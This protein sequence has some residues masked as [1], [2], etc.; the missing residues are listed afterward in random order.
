MENSKNSLVRLIV[1]G[2]DKCKSNF[3]KKT[4]RFLAENG[5][6]AVTNQDVIFPLSYLYV[7]K[8]P[9]NPYYKNDEIL[10][11][12]F[13]GGDA[14]RNA[15]DA[16]GKVEFVKIDGSK[17]GKTYMCWS[18]FHW[19]ET[20]RLLKNFLPSERANSWQE[21]LYIAFEGIFKEL[22]KSK[23]HNIPTWNAMAI[24][25]AG[26]TFQNE[27]WQKGAKK[28]I[29][30][31]VKSMNP[32][33]YWQEGQGPTTSYNLVY[34]HSLGLYYCASKDEFVI[35]SLKTATDF[36]IHFTYP[37]GSLVETIDGRV[38]YNSNPSCMGLPGFLT[39]EKGKRFSAFLV[40]NL[41]LK[42]PKGLCS[43]YLTSALEIWP[44]EIKPKDKIIQELTEYSR[45]Y[46]GNAIVRKHK[47]FYTCLS[48]Y[49]APAKIQSE[50]SNNRWIQ[51][52]SN[53]VSIWYKLC[54][55]IIG[56]GNSK[57]QPTWANFSLW[58]GTFRLWCPDAS[59]VFSKENEDKV[60]LDFAGTKCS[61][62]V[63]FSGEKQVKIMFEVI[64]FSGADKIQSSLLLCLEKGTRVKCGKY[65][66]IVDPIYSEVIF[67]KKSQTIQTKH[68][69][70][71]SL[72]KHTFFYWPE[73]PFNPYAIN[74]ASPPESARGKL[75]FELTSK[76]PKNE[77]LIRVK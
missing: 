68:Y 19:L 62:S 39:T 3:D 14:L 60:I 44:D 18:M 37:D 28:F 58:K 10:N 8:H 33:G 73:Y 38:K 36:H 55:L 41:C 1:K 15:Q 25:K 71:K 24:F 40:K 63:R 17:W 74:G 53:F 27:K 50:L 46:N 34:V 7:N 2:V 72:K 16:D 43:P 61:I 13:C 5:G 42:N 45:V 48:G 69:L 4:G 35:P 59:Q 11:L 65:K 20:F 51:D 70:I 54:G 6:W 49:V 66:F 67:V 22:Q 64:K 30:K 32:D 12:C 23:V 21:G 47:N 75:I 77:I 56:G 29:K 57:E 26:L 76:S 52:R 31:V 9:E